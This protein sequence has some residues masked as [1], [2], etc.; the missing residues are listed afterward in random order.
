MRD[1]DDSH[2]LGPPASLVAVGDAMPEAH[3]SVGL[4]I[5]TRQIFLHFPLGV[6]YDFDNLLN[7]HIMREVIVSTE[8]TKVLGGAIGYI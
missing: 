7:G 8:G 5:T 1:F 6:G 3:A 4:T 2:F